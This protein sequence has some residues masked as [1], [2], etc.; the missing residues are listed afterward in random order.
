MKNVSILLPLLALV[1]LL[2]AACGGGG[3]GAAGLSKDDV[4]VV[5]D[6]HITVAQ[7]NAE[8]EQ[9]KQSYAQSG[10]T[11]PKQGTSAYQAVKSQAITLLVQ[12]AERQAKAKEMGITVSDKEVQDRLDAIKK[13]HFADKNGKV[14]EAKYQAQ[15]KKANI[16]EAQLRDDI[17]QQLVEEKLYKKLTAGITVSD[18]A[19][20]AYYQ[21]HPDQYSQ[22]KSRD[23]QYMLIKK[24]AL[25]ASL[26]AQLQ[27]NDSYALFCKLAK[28]YSG[29]PS[30]AKTCGK[31]TFSQGQTVAA[32][33]SV[34]FSQPTGKTHAPVYDA[35]SYKAYFLIR[36]LKAAK[37]RQS[38]PFSQLKQS[39]KQTL[40]QQQ[41]SA[42]VNAWSAR[43]TK[44]YCSG[45][46]IKF[47]VGD[48]PNPGPCTATTPTT[49]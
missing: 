38:T 4:A 9:A 27:K 35:T 34:L 49:T 42:A 36:P 31:A 13:Q 10:Q 18:A 24:K 40:A 1:A 11:F 28:Q 43:T 32:F 14:D 15:L 37:P 23:V 48:E 17:R 46:K 45:G 19:A 12:H 25:A 44:E 16:T 22:P 5:G 2:A 20:L 29:D 33:D 6:Q 7:L 21:A 39:I 47:Q 41:D 3:G 30:T 26:Y 8:M